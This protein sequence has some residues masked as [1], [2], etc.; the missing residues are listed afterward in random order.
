MRLTESI[1]KNLKEANSKK[2]KG[3]NRLALLTR[4]N[5]YHDLEKE[6]LEY[7]AKIPVEDL[8]DW[9]KA[10]G[11]DDVFDENYV[12]P[13]N[14]GLPSECLYTRMLTPTKAVCVVPDWEDYVIEIFNYSLITEKNEF[15]PYTSYLMD[16]DNGIGRWVDNVNAALRFSTV[17]D[18]IKEIDK[19][20]G[21]EDKNEIE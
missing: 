14:K 13:E 9:I 7:L 12:I 15:E 18:A 3:I 16:I 5:D 17:E 21:G 8:V 1:L 11:Y 6:D 2:T 19:L 4:L 20:K 10:N